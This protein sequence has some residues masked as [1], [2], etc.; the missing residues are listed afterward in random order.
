MTENPDGE[1][2]LPDEAVGTVVLAAAGGPG[3]TGS[4][5]SFLDERLQG[6]GLAVLAI[7]PLHSE[8]APEGQ[9]T[10]EAGLDVLAERLVAAIDRVHSELPT[11]G[12][13]VGVFGVDSAAAGT[14]LA[15]SRRPDTVR[16]V[17]SCGGRP[18]LLS[19]EV[20]HAIAA[21]ALLMVGDEGEPVRHRELLADLGSSASTVEVIAGAGGLDH[22]GAVE[23]VAELAIGWLKRHLASGMPAATETGGG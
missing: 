3:G 18:D 22:P 13:P 9:G 7:D 23:V 20:R 11:A 10:G 14:L 15:A 1:L 12:L 21:P 17:V 19:V 6:A 2:Y 16:A 4:S 5:R 8:K